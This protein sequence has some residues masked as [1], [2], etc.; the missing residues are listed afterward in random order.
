MPLFQCQKCGALENTALGDFWDSP[1]HLCSECATGKWH[2]AFPKQ[3]AYE[4]GCYV[5]AHGFVYLPDEVDPK[6]LRWNYNSRFR[7]VGVVKPVK[8]S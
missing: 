3:D 1:E 7:M 6:T 5:D 8:N 2:G 4:L